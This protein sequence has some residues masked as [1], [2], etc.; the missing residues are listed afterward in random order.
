MCAFEFQIRKLSS[1]QRSES[2]SHLAAFLVEIPPASSL[3]NGFGGHSK[4]SPLADA[5]LGG[6]AHLLCIVPYCP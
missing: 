3:L 5:E 2:I 1:E 6:L 4:L